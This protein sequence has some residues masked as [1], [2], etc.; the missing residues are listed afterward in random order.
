MGRWKGPGN[1]WGCWTQKNSNVLHPT[2]LYAFEG[3]KRGSHGNYVMSL[4]P[5]F[6]R[7]VG[8][9]QRHSRLRSAQVGGGHCPHP[10]P[11]G[12]SRELSHAAV[13][14]PQVLSLT[15][16]TK[17][18]HVKH[19]REQMLLRPLSPAPNNLPKIPT[20]APWENGDPT[21]VVIFTYFYYVTS[22]IVV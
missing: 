7:G 11:Q 18:T 19:L 21:S 16:G 6:R 10:T 13:I 14:Y 9:S 20:Q 12:A 17:Q 5:Q 1:G 8:P 4:L 15:L 22:D 3:L 2:E